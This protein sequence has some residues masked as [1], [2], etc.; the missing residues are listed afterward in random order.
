[1][2]PPQNILK[3]TLKFF[4]EIFLEG[5]TFVWLY[6]LWP[7]KKSFMVFIV[8]LCVRSHSRPWSI[9]LIK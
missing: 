2:S 6:K 8:V 3:T 1:M 7:V 4:P 9:C 5:K